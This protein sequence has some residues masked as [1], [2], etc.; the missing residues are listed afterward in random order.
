M[1][2]LYS[3]LAH[4]YEAMY[5]TFIDYKEQYEL[6]KDFLVKYDK[7]S[8]L[9][10]ACGTGKLSQ[11]FEED[12]Y[13]YLGL[14]L[15]PEMLKIAKE[16]NPTASYIVSDMRSFQL[17]ETVGSVIIPARS[18][19]YLIQNEDV[20]ST[21]LSI[22]NSLEQ[23]GI[24]CFDFIDASRFIPEIGIEKTFTHEAKDKGVTYIREGTWRPNLISGWS[25][26]WEATYYKMEGGTS[27]EIGKDSSMVR[28]FTKDEIELFL[29]RN[30]FEVKE[31]FARETYAFPTYVV[32][33]QKR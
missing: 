6:Y 2:N 20:E 8:V 24:L 15:S 7:K 19:S 27:I 10:I 4:V 17:D 13:D 31:I 14:D 21:L 30:N 1:S 26:S 28:S 12:M 11:Y 22:H 18:I 32:V 25:M 16:R 5:N 23:G 3:E 9:E 29:Y 33:G